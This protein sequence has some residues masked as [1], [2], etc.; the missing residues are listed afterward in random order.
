MPLDNPSSLSLST[1]MDAA[2][3]LGEQIKTLFDTLS[4]AFLMLNGAAF[5]LGIVIMVY[6]I[7]A[8]VAQTAHDG[9]FLGKRYSSIWVPIKLVTGVFL[10]FPMFNGFALAQK[11]VVWAAVA[12]VGLANLV[13]GALLEF[14]NK[15]AT[16][17]SAPSA[18]TLANREYVRQACLYGIFRVGYAHAIATNPDLAFDPPDQNDCGTVEM[19]KSTGN[20]EIDAARAKSFQSMSK[21]LAA[22]VERDYFNRMDAVELKQQIANAASAYADAMK[23]GVPKSSPTTDTKAEGWNWTQF[24]FAGTTEAIRLAKLSQQVAELPKIGDTR[25]A[26]T[27]MWA[28]EEATGCSVG[29]CPMSWNGMR[30]SLSV[31]LGIDL[32]RKS[33]SDETTRQSDDGD[34]AISKMFGTSVADGFKSWAADWMEGGENNPILFGQELGQTMLNILA[35]ALGV[36]LLLS[37]FASAIMTMTMAF[38]IPLAALAIMLSSYLPL[39]PSLLWLMALIPWAVKILEGLLGVVLWAMAHLDPEGEGMG[40]RAQKGYLFLVD[41]IF[42]PAFLVVAFTGASI[43]TTF[44]AKLVNN[45]FVRSL[46]DYQ[47]T[48]FA[49]LFGLVGAFLVAALAII[50]IPSK[51]YAQCLAIPDAIISWMGGQISGATV[52]HNDVKE[53]N[54]GAAVSDASK[55]VGNALGNATKTK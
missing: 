6:V 41:L 40:Q 42:R 44:I 37:L 12:G 11:A 26:D 23:S 15:P 7:V 1:M 32:V 45:L 24:G 14:S 9:E 30:H 10:I 18:I 3:P 31:R 4:P 54:G 48:G 21:N 29:Q 8:G 19:P 46:F 34:A 39:I 49:S 2:G 33:Q 5:A 25:L 53:I 52:S 51:V 20:K 43:I 16:L 28:D 38:V 47:V 13:G 22:I 27:S 55:G 36:A 50:G 17:V 35:A